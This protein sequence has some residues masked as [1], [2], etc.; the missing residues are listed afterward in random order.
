MEEYGLVPA[1]A[2]IALTCKQHGINTIATLDK[3]FMRVHGSKLFL[4]DINRN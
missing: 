2:V 4:E 3:D 1:D